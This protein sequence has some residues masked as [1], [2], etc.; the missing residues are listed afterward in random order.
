[1]LKSLLNVNDGLKGHVLDVVDNKPLL[2]L[3]FLLVNLGSFFLLSFIFSIIFIQVGK[4]TN[5]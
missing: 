5:F 2:L 3:L 1:M 4:G